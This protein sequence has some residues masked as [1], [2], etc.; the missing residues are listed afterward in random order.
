MVAIGE[1]LV[2]CR[3]LLKEDRVWL[4]WLSTEF[5]WSRRTANRFVDLYRA[6]HKLGNLPTLPVSVLYLLAKASP[7]V[8]NAVVQRIEAG[9]RPTYKAV[10]V[11]VET[12]AREV[13]SVAYISPPADDTPRKIIDAEALASFEALA[14]V[15]RLAAFAT[16]I[17]HAPAP[18]EIAAAV[19]L[20]QQAAVRENAKMVADFTQQLAHA[21]FAGPRLKLVTGEGDDETMH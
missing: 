6:R 20:R 5:S 21:S 8:H 15:Q 16:V 14:F 2:E 13:R 1:R 18:D 10:R 7:S 11:L 19:P 12:E 17:S 3:K 4:A 9:E